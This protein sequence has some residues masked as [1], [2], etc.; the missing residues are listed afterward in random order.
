[1]LA[2]FDHACVRVCE[3]SGMEVNEFMEFGVGI[4]LIL[5]WRC[6]WRP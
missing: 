2:M 4:G 6:C 5:V 1:M 3:G